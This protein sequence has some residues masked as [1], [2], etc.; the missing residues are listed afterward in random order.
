MS[1]KRINLLPPSRKRS[2]IQDYFSRLGVVALVLTSILAITATLLLIPTYGFLSNDL[3]SKQAR[4]ASSEP[5]GSVD[6]AG[7]AERLNAL[8]KS[9]ARILALKDVSP[10]SPTVREVLAVPR[11]GITITNSTIVRGT[12]AR[13]STISISGDAKTRDAL[14]QYQLS[15]QGAPFARSVSL[16]VSAYAKDV[17]IPFTITVT[18]AL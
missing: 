13:P 12:D 18:L 17:N 10:V 8:A 1:N 14:R 7:P 15:L 4:L 6:R 3:Q 5:E 9:T 2:L 16:P 11:A